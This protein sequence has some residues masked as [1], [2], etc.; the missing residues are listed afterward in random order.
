MCKHNFGKYVMG[1]LLGFGLGKQ[2][3]TLTNF[4]S[5]SAWAGAGRRYTAYVLEKA[6]IYCAHEE[7]HCIVE[8]LIDKVGA[9][10]A[11]AGHVA[12][13]TIVKILLE[14]PEYTQK[15]QNL[16]R[17]HMSQLLMIKYARK[18]LRD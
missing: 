11:L 14:L 4:L 8:E 17:P 9:F 6:F 2:K 18:A 7:R 12:S 1:H 5:N 10:V 13:R 16:F 15:V 3:D